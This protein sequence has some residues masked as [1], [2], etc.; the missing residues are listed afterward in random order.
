MLQVLLQQ[1]PP[2]PTE[3][4]PYKKQCKC[5]SDPTWSGFGAQ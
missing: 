3:Y 1:E 2:E 5:S 4:K